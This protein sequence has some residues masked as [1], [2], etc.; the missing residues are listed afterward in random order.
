MLDQLI[1]LIYLKNLY[2]VQS[3]S[4][5][6]KGLRNLAHKYYKSFKNYKE[7]YILCTKKY[8]IRKYV[9]S[10]FKLLLCKSNKCVLN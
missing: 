8:G 3:E 5:K 7:S 10:I 9:F 2:I 4:I 6:T 1:C